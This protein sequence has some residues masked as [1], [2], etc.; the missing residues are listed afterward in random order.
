MALYLLLYH[1]NF[2]RSKYLYG[3]GLLSLLIFSPVIIYNILL[4]QT[5]GH[6]DFQWSY[7]FGQAVDYWQVTPG[8]EIDTLAGR[9]LGI[10]RN[11]WFYN[12]PIFNVLAGIS[13]LWFIRSWWSRSDNQKRS[14]IFLLLLV[15]FNLILYLLIGPSPR[16]L[17]MFI[18]AL[19]LL[20][21]WFISY[22]LDIY[23]RYQKIFYAVLFLWLLVEA[24]YSINSYIFYQPKG[25]PV[26]N[27]S[28]IHWDMHPWGF[29][30][31][32]QYLDRLLDQQYPYLTVP[33][34]YDFL[35]KIKKEHLQEAQAQGLSPAKIILIYDE[36]ISDLGA[37]WTLNRRA[38][39]RAWPIL[40]VAAWRE[41]AAQPEAEEVLKGYS[42]YFIQPAENMLLVRESERSSQGQDLAKELAARDLRPLTI[43]NH[44]GQSAFYIYIWQF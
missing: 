30:A 29:N 18:P 42:F 15:I 23:R 26:W 6:F 32:G 2:F 1:R 14:R 22:I 16:F 3:G 39:Y 37:L 20:L 25:R 43:Y 38:L 40:P 10:F 8:K 17:S 9:F 4:W 24:A 27:Y 19:S 28:Q 33:Y 21:A 44:N 36:N 35:E 13:W 5:F 34:S 12:S 7:F 31:L 11:F 41:L